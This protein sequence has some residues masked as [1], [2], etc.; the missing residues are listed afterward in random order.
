MTL[1]TVRS[2][3]QNAVNPLRCLTRAVVVLLRL[4]S[5]L[6]LAGLLGL[7]VQYNREMQHALKAEETDSMQ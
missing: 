6:L 2:Q 3:R 7:P 4:H 5:V 1:R